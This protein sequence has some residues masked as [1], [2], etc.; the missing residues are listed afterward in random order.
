MLDLAQ[1]LNT[2]RMQRLLEEQ[3][4][5]LDGMDVLGTRETQVLSASQAFA[6]SGPVN[7]DA[8]GRPLEDA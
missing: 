4:A 1:R 3:S 8:D 6:R 5:M 2:V 7:V